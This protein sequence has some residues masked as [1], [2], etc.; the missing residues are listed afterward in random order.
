MKRYF[1]LLILFLTV[2]FS[3]NS[4]SVLSLALDTAS[5]VGQ[6][7]LLAHDVNTFVGTHKTAYTFELID[8]ANDGDISGGKVISS[9]AD[10]NNKALFQDD[11]IEFSYQYKRN[12]IVPALKGRTNSFLT[13][14]WNDVT[15]D[16]TLKLYWKDGGS[17][18]ST[19]SKAG[20]NEANLYSV[21][22]SVSNT[23][24]TFPIYT[25]QKKADE[26]GLSG[27]TFALTFPIIKGDKVISYVATFKISAITVG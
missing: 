22:D 1:N 13:I 12:Y 19:I 25:S 17:G 27:K 9:L 16:G 5:L 14:N 26:S 18:M 6:S 15:M 3:L 23:Y 21:Y 4:C 24:L 8:V 11:L 2:I 20:F 10:A 7:A